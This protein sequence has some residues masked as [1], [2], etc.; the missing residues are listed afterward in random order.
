MTSVDTAAYD[1]PQSVTPPTESGTF[2]QDGTVSVPPIPEIP[3]SRPAR[4]WSPVDESN[5][6]ALSSDEPVAVPVEDDAVAAAPSR[7]PSAKVDSQPP[8]ADIPASASEVGV[9]QQQPPVYPAYSQAAPGPQYV[10]PQQF[11]QQMPP[12][13]PHYM[14]PQPSHNPP[15]PGAGAY[16]APQQVQHQPGVQ[17][18]QNPQA[19]QN[20]APPPGLDAQ[21]LVP[22]RQ[23][24]APGNGWR[25]T[26]HTVSGGL[27]TFGASKSQQ[28]LDMMVQRV[29]QPVRGDFRLAVLSLKGGVGKTTTTLGLGSAFAS[30][31]GD[32]VIAVDANPDLGTLASRIPQETTSTVRDLLNDEALHRYTDVRRHTNQAPSRLEVLASERDPAISEAF[33]ADDYLRVVGILENYYNIIMTDCGTG[34]MHSAMQGVLSTANAIVVVTSPAVDGAQSASAT[35]D[36]LNAHGYQR[37]VSQAV[38]VISASKPGGAPVDIEVLTEHFLGR[39]RAV[40]IVPYD[41]HLAAGAHVDLDQMHRHTRTA[42]LEL[43]ATVADSFSTT[44]VPPRE[45]RP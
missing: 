31:R 4:G 21:R 26:L 7:L 39:C 11:G 15:P 27:I 22:A 3:G 45:S 13:A 43:A 42:F 17:F 35:L 36:W 25:R 10:A 5:S 23:T 12:A 14:P 30:L 37:L 41:N 44:T 38:V 19:P 2:A 32:R 40:Q 9:H 34:L 29:R 8:A 20:L 33:S 1:S 6:D 24:R 16:V 18:P 28:Q